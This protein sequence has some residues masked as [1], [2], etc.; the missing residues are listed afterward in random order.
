MTY[1]IYKSSKDLCVICVVPCSAADTSSFEK[2]NLAS[3]L[4]SLVS[5]KSRS[6]GLSVVESTSR[7]PMSD[8]DSNRG[9]GT[10]IVIGTIT[11]DEGHGTATSR[12]I[13]GK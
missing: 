4:T 12:L 7:F 13:S 10:G 2:K 6:T 3:E 1:G 8:G 9:R 5:P 11:G